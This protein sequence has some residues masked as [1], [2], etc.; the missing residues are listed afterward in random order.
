MRVFV[1]HCLVAS[2]YIAGPDAQLCSAV[3]DILFIDDGEIRVG[4]D[5][6]KG[7]AITWL[8][9]KSYPQNMVNL[10]DPGR[11][12]QQSYYAGKRLNRQSEGQHLN[13]SPWTW[14][15]IQGGG[16][17]S[18]GSKG[19]WA[20]VTA[21]RGTTSLL[22]SETI[23]K[24]WDMRD[25]EAE[26]VMKQW[27][28][29]EEGLT[30][31][32]K[33]RCQVVCTRQLNDRWGAARQSPQEVP[34]CYFTRRFSYTASYLGDGKWRS[35]TQA[36]GPPW[37]TAKP[38]L[39]AMAAFDASGLGVGV[40][41]PT[42]DQHWNFGPHG[43]GDSGDP[44]AGPCLHIAPVSRIKLGPQATFGYRY[45]LVVGDRK[46]IA[47]RFDD[48]VRKYSNERSQLTEVGSLRQ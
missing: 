3:D 22:Y 2:A 31:V 15:P 8:S 45:W 23:P 46:T 43:S 48:L 16:V 11:L 12:I 4:I 38:P 25:E 19:T 41:S 14:N 34:A 10:A 30:G 33:V 36:P 27:T 17:G 13:W 47:S 24:L 29:F 26:A 42:S 39:K 32:A 7:A 1:I 35:E 20:N 28:E 40:F 18:G 37:G 6:R 9:S 5:S 21:F 44:L